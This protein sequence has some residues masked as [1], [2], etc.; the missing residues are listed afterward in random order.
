[1]LKFMKTQKMPGQTRGW[2]YTYDGGIKWHQIDNYGTVCRAS[3]SNCSTRCLLA[4]PGPLH[5][6]LICAQ[7]GEYKLGDWLAQPEVGEKLTSATVRTLT[8][9]AKFTGPNITKQQ[10]IDNSAAWVYTEPDTATVDNIPTCDDFGN[11]DEGPSAS[12]SV[13]N[14]AAASPAVTPSKR[15]RK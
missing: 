7:P 1:M 10:A 5:A 15:Q 6:L 9:K 2:A 13:A 14:S 12:S 3:H 8:F 4:L 11:G